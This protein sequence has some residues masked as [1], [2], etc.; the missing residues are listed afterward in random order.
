MKI[1]LPDEKDLDV[2][3]RV[4]NMKLISKMFLS[5]EN[6]D[7][8]LRALVDRHIN[9]RVKVHKFPQIGGGDKCDI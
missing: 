9:N 4:R 7:Y 3:I 1:N 8:A 5:Q 6:V 2:I